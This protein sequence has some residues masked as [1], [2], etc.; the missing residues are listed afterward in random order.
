M[1]E[2]GDGEGAEGN[3]ECAGNGKPACVEPSPA[4]AGKKQGGEGQGDGERQGNPTGFEQREGDGIHRTG[5]EPCYASDD[6]PL[7][8]VW[9]APVPHDGP[10]DGGG[11][12][13]AHADLAAP[14]S[15]QGKRGARRRARSIRPR[16]RSR[17]L[18][19]SIRGW[20]DFCPTLH[21][22]ASLDTG[23]QRWVRHTSLG[24]LFP[25][26]LRTW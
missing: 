17:R 9:V 6:C 23:E 4:G 14:P 12:A 26:S 19:R 1:A 5:F 24:R 13:L 18:A 21:G 7:D 20:A 16:E 15:A 11:G 22:Q 25:R 10:R 3:G 2:A 8:G